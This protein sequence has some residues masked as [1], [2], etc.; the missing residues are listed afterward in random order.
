[1]RC[2]DCSRKVDIVNFN[3]LKTLELLH[4]IENEKFGKEIVYESKQINYDYAM[5]KDEKW[6]NKGEIDINQIQLR[7]RKKFDIV[8][9]IDKNIVIKAGDKIGICGRTGSGKS[10]ILV[11]IFRLFEPLINNVDIDDKNIDKLGLYDL[12]SNLAIVAQNP[13]LFH[14]D[15]RF[16]L[17][18]FN[19]YSDNQIWNALINLM[20]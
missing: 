7:Y 16:N 6:P 4:C 14:G 5:L 11:S 2:L 1:M 13:V 12:R 3:F 20:I 10:S 8:L 19:K 15:L 18:P 17:D 9:D